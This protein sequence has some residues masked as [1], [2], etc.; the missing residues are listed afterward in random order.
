MVCLISSVYADYI[1][2]YENFFEV[3]VSEKISLLKNPSSNETAIIIIEGSFAVMNFTENY[4]H[5]IYVSNAEEEDLDFFII[6]YSEFNITTNTTIGDD[7]REIYKLINNDTALYGVKNIHNHTENHTLGD[8]QDLYICPFLK[9]QVGTPIIRPFKALNKSGVLNFT[10]GNEITITNTV[11]NSICLDLQYIY[12]ENTTVPYFEYVGFQCVNCDNTNTIRLGVD[13]NSTQENTSIIF[14]NSTNN[15]EFQVD[16][17]MFFVFSLESELFETYT[18]TAR[19]RIPFYV[20][21]TLYNNFNETLETKFDYIYLKESSSANGLTGDMGTQV[22]NILGGISGTLS[23]GFLDFTSSSINTDEVFWG[24]VVDD[25]ALIKLYE[26]N[27]YSINLLTV[28]TF[29]ENGWNYEFYKPQYTDSK[30]ETS[31]DKRVEILNGTSINLRIYLSE[32]E[33]NKSAF[34]FNIGKWIV[35]FIILFGGMYASS[36]TESPAKLIGALIPVWLIFIKI[37][38]LI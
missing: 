27:N 33:A 32:Y 38:G 6:V 31:L 12:P 28:K 24:E 19:F 14:S 30:V 37:I 29:Q 5:S 15:P 10:Y 13:D 4:G 1:L 9:K 16:D 17:F 35:A 7:S 11:Y 8:L 22:S 23:F 21:I 18:G 2:S 3:G 34:I 25:T 20:N 26:A 36:K